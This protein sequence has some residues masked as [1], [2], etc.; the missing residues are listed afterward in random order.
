MTD[1]ICDVCKSRPATFRTEVLVNGERRIVDLCDE[2]YRKLAR[3]LGRNTSPLESLFGRS[4]LFD[5]FFGDSPFGGS[6]FDRLGSSNEGRSLPV[7]PL[8]RQPRRGGINIADRLSEQA[9]SPLQ[10]AVQKAH[11]FGRSEV[12]TEHLE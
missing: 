5:E 11:D 2:D 1:D 7:G 6:L 3:R 10:K 12:D 9:N 4:S 8:S